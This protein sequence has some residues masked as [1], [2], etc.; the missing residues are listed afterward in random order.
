MMTSM[1]L[2]CFLSLTLNQGYN[3]LELHKDSRYITFATHAGLHQYT[4]L[5]FGINST[6][7]VF[8]EASRQAL[9]GLEGV[10]SLSDYI[11]VFGKDQQ[12]HNSNLRA[13]FQRL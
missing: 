12:S 13:V 9:T 11:L 3:Q 5:N 10:F 2:Q 7:E 4:R 6:A 1:A 8:Q